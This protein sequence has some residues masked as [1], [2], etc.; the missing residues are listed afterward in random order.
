[1]TRRVSLPLILAQR[2]LISVACCTAAAIGQSTP[3]AV[4]TSSK[5]PA[6][7]VVSIRPH[8]Q[9][10]DGSSWASPTPNGYEARNASVR[11]LLE[12]A[13]DVRCRDQLAGLPD[14]AEPSG[15]TFD[16][17]AR[18]D[19]DA[20]VDFQKLSSDRQQAQAALML[21]SLLADRFKLK[22]H[23][24]TRV[25]SVYALMVAKSGFKLKQSEAP[26]NLY[27]MMEGRNS[28]YIRGGPI[29]AR[30]IAG[31]SDKTGR[32]VIDKTGLTGSYDIDFKWTPD[33]DIAAGVSGPSLF[34]ALEEQLGLK[35]VPAKAPLD[36]LVIDHIEK[37][38]EN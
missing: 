31:L 2:I 30:F 36:V 29:G 38:S 10:I 8:K 14:W 18:M 7:D 28:I 6:F 16:I 32:I 25:I 11:R 20:L 33:E 13:Y 37:P 4:S 3:T 17:E 21:Q 1:M 26:E 15:G 12:R 19:G 5:P 27:G 35:L 34:T 23:H 22:V 24:E 9:T